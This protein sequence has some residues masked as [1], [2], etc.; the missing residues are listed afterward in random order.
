MSI[1]YEFSNDLRTRNVQFPWVDGLDTL[2]AGTPLDING[3]IVNDDTAV[4]IVA[5]DV[6]RNWGR[7]ISADGNFYANVTVIVAGYID[8]AAAES[9]C[10]L[11][12][13]DAL[14]GALNDIVFVDGEIGSGGGGGQPTEKTERTVYIPEQTA[15]AVTPQIGD[16]FYPITADGKLPDTFTMSVDGVAETLVFDSSRVGG[17]WVG[18]NYSVTPSHV[19]GGE[20]YELYINESDGV[21]PPT[22][23][24]VIGYTETTVYSGAGL[25]DYT[26]DDKGKVLTLGE[27]ASTVT[28][29]WSQAKGVTLYTNNVGSTDAYSPSNLF[30]ENNFSLDNLIETPEEL[31]ELSKSA[32]T[33][34][35]E[36]GATVKRYYPCSFY[37]E[38]GVA[39]LTVIDINN[40]GT[41][42]RRYF[43][44]GT[45]K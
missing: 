45:P 38:S 11:E 4:G 29:I 23:V 30:R 43:G 5:E 28:P 27:D 33:I 6:P 8:E 16:P 17:A 19:V 31:A 18:N 42:T 13:T 20:G 15:E 12:Y 1:L 44:A 25:P 10:G 36:S 24:T 21:A 26:S 14:K 35:Y 7:L 40:S 2:K 37:Q 22:S 39:V 34:V 41:Q 32:V 3:A 9:S